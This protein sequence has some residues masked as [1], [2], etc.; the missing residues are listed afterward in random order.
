MKIIHEKLASPLHLK[1]APEPPWPE[2]KMFYLLSGSGM[3]LCRNHP[4]F[5]SSV[6][7]TRPPAGLAAHAP[8]LRLNYPRLA[9]REF[10]RAIGFFSVIAERFSAEAAVLL[11]WNADRRAVEIVVPDQTSYVSYGSNGAAWPVEVHY[12]TPALP[13]HLTVIGDV[14]CHVDLAAYASSMDKEDET[15]RPGLHLVVGRIHLE[16]PEFHLEAVVDGMRFRVPRLEDVIEGYQQRRPREVPP[17]WIDR[18]AIEP[19]TYQAPAAGPGYYAPA[20]LTPVTPEA[21]RDDQRE[22]FTDQK[23]A[24]G[25]TDTAGPIPSAGTRKR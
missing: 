8:F 19:W 7:V 21:V 14:H 2:E 1:L 5:R 24:G 10:E 18:V 23:P 22:Q 15:H 9:R 6:P 3:F 25:R 13:P 11:V 16:P 12:Q 4:F 17:E 20:G